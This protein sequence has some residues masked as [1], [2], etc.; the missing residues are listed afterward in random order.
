MKGLFA[1]YRRE[2]AG[3]FVSPLA[4]VLLFL[5]LLLNGW[6]F[7]VT[8]RDYSGDVTQS[9]RF[10]LGFS[11]PF[12]IL[13]AVLPPLLSM[14]TISE[15]SNRGLLEFLL[16]APVTDAAVVTGKFL[17]VL[18][19][20]SVLWSG[21][22]LYGLAVQWAGQA[23]DWIP[24]LGGVLGAV[25]C[26]ALFCAVGILSSAATRTPMLSFFLAFVF[27]AFVLLLPFTTGY[28]DSELFQSVVRRIDIVSHFHRSFSIGVLDTTAVLFFVAWTVFFVFLSIKLVEMRRWRA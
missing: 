26:S 16:T 25:L 27:N 9:L 22:L 12:W 3:L 28:L 19:F 18:T 10:V 20:M 4:W 24:L 5:A 17:A 15:E 2:L 1:I 21:T 23:P 11:I 14:R 6:L 7:V 8:L 13:M